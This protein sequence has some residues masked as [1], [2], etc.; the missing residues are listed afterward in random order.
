MAAFLNSI[1]SFF[2]NYEDEDYVSSDIED[3]LEDSY[4]EIEKPIRETRTQATARR[5]FTMD[6]S[7]APVIR[8][9]KA[10]DDRFVDFNRLGSQQVVVVKP[11]NMDDG[12][13]IANEIRAGRVVVCNFEEVDHRLAQRIIDFLTGSAFSLGGRVMPI[14][15]LIFIITPMHIALSDGLSQ[16]Q[17]KTSMEN[18]RKVVNAF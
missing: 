18:L 9:T 11:Q 3:T 6:D 8:E 4:E 17:E 10:Q 13:L 2:N 12:Q 7:V 15:S 1:K 14:S 16:N 5:T